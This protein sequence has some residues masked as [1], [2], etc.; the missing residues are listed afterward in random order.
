MRKISLN[1]LPKVFPEEIIEILC[2]MEES[3][4][5]D[6]KKLFNCMTIEQHMMYAKGKGTLQK[7]KSDEEWKSKSLPEKKRYHMQF[8]NHYANHHLEIT[9][10]DSMSDL[11]KNRIENNEMGKK[12][13]HFFWETDSPF[14]QWYLSNFIGETW[15]WGYQEGRMDFLEGHFPYGEQEYSSA[16]QFMMYHKAM[17]FMDFDTAHKIMATKDV[18]KIKEFGRQVKNFNDTVWAFYRTHIVWNGN[19][20]K[21]TSSD[22]L[23]QALFDTQG[24]TL[25]EAAPNDP[26]WGIGL[27]ADDPLALDRSTWKGK[28]LLG[29]ILTEIRVKMMGHY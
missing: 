25:V 3:Q 6:W 18:R 24:K 7:R 10:E 9:F 1:E 5:E 14:S 17:L 27:A 20:A 29:E 22:A 16:E 15:L 4:S 12:S 26:I 2:E 23:R 19:F 21:F 13:Y 8:I 11:V 28:N